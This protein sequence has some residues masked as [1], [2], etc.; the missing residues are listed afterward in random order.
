MGPVRGRIGANEHAERRA[1][2]DHLRDRAAFAHPDTGYR[3]P[4]GWL[5]DNRGMRREHA[6]KAR[7]IADRLETDPAYG[8]SDAYIDARLHASEMREDYGGFRWQVIVSGAAVSNPGTLAA[9]IADRLPAEDSKPAHKDIIATTARLAELARTVAGGGAVCVVTS[10][11]DPD[12]RRRLLVQL[13]YTRADPTDPDPGV[14]VEELRRGLSDV[15]GRIDLDT[16]E[17]LPEGQV[18]HTVR[19]DLTRQRILVYCGL[20]GQGRTGMSTLNLALCEGLVAAGHEVTVLPQEVDPDFRLPGVQV[21]VG[22]AW[23]Q[24]RHAEYVTDLPRSVDVVVV[25]VEAKGVDAALRAEKDYPTAKLVAVHHL[26][27]MLWET[28]TNHPARG[29]AAVVA[30]I[31]LAR[32]AH[33]VTG[34]GPALAADALSQAAMAGHGSVHE[35][36]PVLDMAEQPPEPASG[37][38][39]WLLLFGR[40]DDELKGVAEIAEVVRRL[41]EQGRDVRLLVRGYTSDLESAHAGLAEAV[42]DPDA[43]EARPH[44]SDR[45]EIRADIRSATV[46]VMPSRAEGFG[47]VGTEAIEQGVPVVVPSTSGVGQFLAG[48]AGYRP[49]AQRLNLVE[50]AQGAPV[51]IDRWVARLGVVIDD[52]PGAWAAARELQDLMRPLTR[53]NSAKMLV[54]ATLNTEPHS[55]PEILPSR[56]SVSRVGVKVVARGEEETICAYSPWPTRW[57]PIPPYAVRSPGDWASSSLPPGNHYPSVSRRWTPAHGCSHPRHDLLYSRMMC[58][59]ASCARRLRRWPSRDS[60]QRPLTKSAGVRE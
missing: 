16:A 7:E 15:D 52:V 27:P 3:P 9:A 17:P 24:D 42:G 12:G 47:G 26:L 6:A 25:H 18:R 41:R 44:T 38:P 36:R 22:D 58:A 8:P 43:V 11:Q 39:V 1:L 4:D 51:P 48:Q 34:L 28:L 13:E 2:I 50:Q 30:G 40:V 37:S 32:R 49:V 59:P 10:S 21:Y 55:R 23:L 33:L 46:V 57:K 29:R 20:W 19:L 14:T 35:L 56:T 54:H 31:F 45:A 60:P 53:E 5:A